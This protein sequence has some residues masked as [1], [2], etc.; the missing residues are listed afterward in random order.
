MFCSECGA[1]NP[2]AARFC[3]GCGHAMTAE[4]RREVPIPKAGQRHPI[5]G[6]VTM[7][8]PHTGELKQI[9]DGFS[10]T[11]FLFWDCLGIPLFL[12]GLTGYGIFGLVFGIVTILLP[13]EAMVALLIVSL[14]VG[15]WLGSIA[16]P[17]HEKALLRE[18]WVYEG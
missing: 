10:W 18:G 1:K 7:R 3:C 15:A 8:N 13:P 11:S 5:N 14:V 4:A 2:D 16:N 12:R 9:K 6:R 17:E